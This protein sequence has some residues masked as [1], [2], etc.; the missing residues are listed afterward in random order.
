MCDC[1]NVSFIL[2]N[3]FHMFG[4]LRNKIQTTYIHIV[5]TLSISL[6]IDCQAGHGRRKGDLWRCLATR[7]AARSRS[8]AIVGGVVSHLLTRA[9]LSCRH[10]ASSARIR[11]R[12]ARRILRRAMSRRSAFFLLLVKFHVQVR[13]TVAEHA[14]TTLLAVPSQR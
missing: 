5:N 10:K 9:G 4:Y 8:T 13:Q 11:L 6:L 3:T 12:T 1:F 7:T 2:Q 14:L